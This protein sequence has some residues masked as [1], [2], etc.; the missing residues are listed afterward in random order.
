MPKRLAKQ[1][2]APAFGAGQAPIAQKRFCS[3]TLISF[4]AFGLRFAGLD[5]RVWG[6]R[7][8]FASLDI[9]VY[10]L[11]LYLRVLISQPNFITIYFIA[12]YPTPLILLD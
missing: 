4:L 5:L 3:L 12:A 2:T 8:R 1:P 6:Y 9:C 10:A 7:V 11:S